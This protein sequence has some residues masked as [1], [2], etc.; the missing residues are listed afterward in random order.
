MMDGQTDKWM[1]RWKEPPG[2]EGLPVWPS[3]GRVPITSVMA[4]LFEGQKMLSL[5]VFPRRTSA[6]ASCLALPLLSALP[7]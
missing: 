6:A 3:K 4:I 7:W 2:E 5:S 1:Y